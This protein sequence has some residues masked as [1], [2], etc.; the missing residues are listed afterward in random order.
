MHFIHSTCSVGYCLWSVS[1]PGQ[2]TLLCPLGCELYG[3]R[4]LVCL[5]HPG[6]GQGHWTV[7]CRT[8]EEHGTEIQTLVSRRW[9]PSQLS[10]PRPG[11][12]PHLKVHELHELG[13]LGLQHFY[14]LLINLY[15]VGLLIAF[16]LQGDRGFCTPWFAQA[17]L[18]HT[19]C[20]IN[21]ARF[22]SRMH[23]I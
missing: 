14:R 1:P 8:N 21:R 5:A 9:G 12:T 13:D 2:N 16:H 15:S 23:F 3:G 10:W 6:V 17:V 18:V 7:F 19:C 22:H 20:L 11:P 4:V